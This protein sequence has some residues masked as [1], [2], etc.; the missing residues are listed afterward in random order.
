MRTIQG[1]SK[2]AFHLLPAALSVGLLL[3]ACTNLE[4]APKASTRAKGGKAA[5]TKGAA[6]LR[7][8]RHAFPDVTMGIPAA[9]TVMLPPGW[10][11][12]GK[13][14][15]QAVGQASFPQQII[16][17]TAPQ[18]GKINMQP[19]AT[20]TYVESGVSGRRGVPAPEDIVQWLIQ[21]AP[22]ADPNVSNVKLIRTSRATQI[23]ELL[24]K[25]DVT[26]SQDMHREVHN[27]V[28]E[29]DEGKVRRREEFQLS[30][31]RFPA[32]QSE[33]FYSQTWSL[34]ASMS[35]SAP[36]TQFAAHRMSLLHVAATLRA[37][38]QWHIQ[39]QAAIAEMARQRTANNWEIIKARGRQ[40]NQLSDDQ[41]DKYKRETASSD[42]AQRQRIQ[43]IYETSDYKDA[44]GD[45]V[46]LPMHYNN[47]FSDGKGN[48][49]LSNNSQD[50][51][52]SGWKA[53]RPMK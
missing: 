40:I 6:T 31:V 4:A 21:S 46:N 8:K 19:L 33:G 28:M 41:Y 16:E 1:Y 45:I 36:A 51:P 3:V 43:G 38:P 50:R 29:Y 47:V 9:Y 35:I 17:V 22:Q 44:N 27:I 52:S 48:Y 13:I 24:N 20:F 7:L 18:Q 39:S 15:W 2:T 53:I 30:Y 10:S 25:T 42:A 11:A 12:E 32:F 34:A 49:V 5:A 26:S 37:T 23:E 14:E